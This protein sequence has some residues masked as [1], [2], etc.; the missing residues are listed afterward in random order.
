MLHKAEIEQ[1]TRTELLALA[2]LASNPEIT[3]PPHLRTDL[4]NK[5]W[6]STTETGSQLLTGRGRALVEDA[7]TCA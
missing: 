6:G 1:V 3:A 4:E 2:R 5:G 7:Q